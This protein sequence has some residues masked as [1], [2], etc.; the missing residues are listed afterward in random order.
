MKIFN[1]FRVCFDIGFAA[2]NSSESTFLLLENPLLKRRRGA[3]SSGAKLSHN[4]IILLLQPES[5]SQYLGYTQA[6]DSEWFSTQVLIR[7]P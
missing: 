6:A 7:V 4:R 3:Y 2:T 5:S 1:T